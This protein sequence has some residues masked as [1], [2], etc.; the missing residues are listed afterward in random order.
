MVTL[1]ALKSVFGNYTGGAATGVRK[2]LIHEGEI[3][4]ATDA[5]AEHLEAQGLAERPHYTRP[6]HDPAS[7]KMQMPPENKMLPV[8]ANKR[9]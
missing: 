6:A 8:T 7:F 1:R 5:D 3:F 2:G 9:R 4:Q